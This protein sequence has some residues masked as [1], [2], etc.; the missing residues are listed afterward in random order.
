MGRPAPDPIS[1]GV[2]SQTSKARAGNLIDIIHTFGNRDGLLM[3]WWLNIAAILGWLLSSVFV[4]SLAGL[5]RS[6]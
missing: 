4:L 1:N 2:D 6:A 3:E 5:A